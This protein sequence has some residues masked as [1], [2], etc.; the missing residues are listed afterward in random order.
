MLVLQGARILGCTLWTDYRLQATQSDRDQMMA[1]AEARLNDHRL[2][3]AQGGSFSTHHALA[4][5]ERSRT[6]LAQRLAEPH[7]GKTLVVTHHGPSRHSVHP[8]Y[9]RDPLNGAFVSDLDEQVAQ[10]D[11]WVHGHVHDSFDYR[12]SGC[13]VVANPRGYAR[14][15]HVAE[16][17]SGLVFENPGFVPACVIE[18]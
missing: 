9:G 6:W 17:A 13:R 4:E 3:R 11:L 8:R 1:E 2:I 14:N 12:V 7:N 15:R 5:H 16:S 18:L 10:A